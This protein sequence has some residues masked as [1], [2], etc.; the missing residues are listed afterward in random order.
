MPTALLICMENTF[1]STGIRRGDNFVELFKKSFKLYVESGTREKVE[2]AINTILINDWLGRPVT[3]SGWED[4]EAKIYLIISEHY[5]CKIHCFYL[6]LTHLITL[7][8]IQPTQGQIRCQ[9]SL[10]S[11]RKRKRKSLLSCKG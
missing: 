7:T 10:K 9:K 3:D 6:Q 2:V 8:E 11:L 4:L 1:W 5:L